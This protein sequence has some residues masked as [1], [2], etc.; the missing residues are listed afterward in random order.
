MGEERNA[1][2]VLTGKGEETRMLGM[3]R[4]SWEDSV[5]MNCEEMGREV[6]D[7]IH[8]AQDRACGGDCEYDNEHSGSPK[9]KGVGDILTG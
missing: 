5:P 9:W 3:P 7:W 1:K 4:C 8:L 2:T 6:V